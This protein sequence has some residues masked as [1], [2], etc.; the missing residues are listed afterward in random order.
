M[1]NLF[2]TNT[3][4]TSIIMTDLG[5][6]HSVFAGAKEGFSAEKAKNLHLI[7]IKTR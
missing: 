6:R 7:Y 2:E 3:N 4:L 5:L 1:T